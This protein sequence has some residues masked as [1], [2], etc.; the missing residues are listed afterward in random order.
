MRAGNGGGD[1]RVEIATGTAV[2][3]P[4]G[5]PVVPLRWVVVRDLVG[6]FRPQTLLCTDLDASAADILTWFVRRWATE[7]TFQEARRHLG[8]A[9]QRQWSD[10]AI[11]RTTPVLLG[12]Y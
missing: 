3:H 6:E 7:V 8:V 5:L 10:L 9:M 2:W 1:R 12:L 11:A 4:P